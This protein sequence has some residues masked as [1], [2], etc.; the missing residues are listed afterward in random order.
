MKKIFLLISLFIVLL[1]SCKTDFEINAK[2]KDIT[3]VYGLLSQS[4]TVHYIK[5]NKAFLGKD[6]ALTMAQNADSSS[7]GKNLDVWVEEWLNGNQTN[8][9]ALNDTVV[10]KDAGTFY[11]PTQEVY[12]FKATLNQNA[13][14]KLYIKNKLTQK[15][16]SAST[17]IVNTFDVQKPSA[18]QSAVFH[19]SNLVEVLWYP[20]VNGK[21]YQVTIRFNYW[22]KDLASGDSTKKYVDWDI[23]SVLQTTNDG[24][25]LT[26]SY[27]GSSF[28]QYIRD[29]INSSS[30]VPAHVLRHMATPNVDFLFSVAADDFNTY[31]EVSA[32]TTGILQNKPQF[33]NIDNGIGIFSSRYTFDRPLPMNPTSIDSLLYGQYTKYLNFQ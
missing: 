27:N 23:G 30:N 6:N 33:T 26:T 32:P 20:A 7:Y 21:L 8:S 15:I 17:P 29:K 25:K 22:E 28:F 5:I 4:E 16:V 14:Y 18:M 12:K 13:V 10:P 24:S 9:W 3:V 2:W 31:L 1:F 11:S 19:A